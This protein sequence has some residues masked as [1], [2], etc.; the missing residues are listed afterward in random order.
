[1]KL[2]VDRNAS[3]ALSPGRPGADDTCSRGNF[4]G[5]APVRRVNAAE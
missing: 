2:K 5:H 1:M 3:V 4:L